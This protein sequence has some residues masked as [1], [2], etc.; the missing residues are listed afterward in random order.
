MA[1]E[2]KGVT[3]STIRMTGHADDIRYPEGRNIK[4]HNEGHLYVLDD[5]NNTLAIYAPGRWHSANVVR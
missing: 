3:V 1:E 4:I 2:R 5:G